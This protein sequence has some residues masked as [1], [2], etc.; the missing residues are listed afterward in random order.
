MRFRIGINL[1]DVIQEGEQIYG[2]GVNIAARIEG[3]VEGGG[4]CISRSAYDQVKNKLPIGYQYLGEHQV[5]NIKDP[6]RVYRVLMERESAGK[7]IGE[8][9]VK[10]RLTLLA[11]TVLFA[12]V[13]GAAAG[14]WHSYFRPP[15][16]EPA[17]VEKMAFPVPD[18]PSI[19]VLPF[20][21]LSGDPKQEYF[22]DGLTEEIIAALGRIPKLFVIARNSTFTYKGKPVKVQRVSEELG[23]RYV[24]EGSVKKAGDKI[25]VTAQLID[26]LDGHH[27]WAE[28]YD[29]NLK[30]IFAVQDEITKEIITAMQVKLTEGEQARA[31][32]KGT[33][34]LDAYLKCLQANE[35]ML[36]INPESNALGKQLAEEAIVLD[37]GYAWAYSILGRGHMQ[38]VWVGMSKS[39]KQSIAKAIELLQKAL[40]LDDTLA[41][42]HSILGFLYS[43]TSEH[44]KGVARAEKAVALNPNSAWTQMMLGKTLSFSSRWEESIPPYKKAIRLNPIPPNMYLWSLGLSY[45]YMEQYEEAITWCEKAIHQQPDSLSAHIMMAV[46]YSLSGREE[47]AR[48]EAAEILRIQSKFSLKKFEKKVTFKKKED[49]EKLIGALRKAGLA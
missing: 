3:L 1:G 8:K 36:R 23:V 7:V 13:V 14:V 49:R 16:I 38:E 26:A 40:V 19:A 21:N 44:E 18:K 22:S 37:P 41:E 34:N 42:T 39:P 28:R 32:A 43:M 10:K 6:V 45:A 29:R 47:G 5:K 15:P 31:T 2:D 17:S 9:R 11:A 30:D 46:V 33:N 35:Y 4:I 20:N 27:L 24:L 25:R 48:I 12:V